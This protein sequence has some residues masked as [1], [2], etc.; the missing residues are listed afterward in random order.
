MN[1]KKKSALL[2]VARRLNEEGVF[3]GVGASFALYMHGLVGKFH[4]FDLM[5]RR[6]DIHAA[7]RVFD[8]LGTGRRTPPDDVY[9]TE[10][11]LEY[12]IDGTEFD[13]MCNLAV[14]TDGREYVYRFEDCPLEHREID[15]VDIPLMPLE[16]WYAIY[17]ILPGREAKAQLLLRH[18]QEN[19]C[20]HPERLQAFLAD[21]PAPKKA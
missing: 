2:K 12:D 14:R 4:D 11:F 21:L 7:R 6:A 18:L 20:A 10:I 15:H 19:G 17:R 5:V 9:R 1:E 13:V 16:D 3:W 8:S